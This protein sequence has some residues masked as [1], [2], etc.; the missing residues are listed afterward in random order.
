MSMPIGDYQIVH[1]GTHAFL[2]SQPLGSSGMLLSMVDQNGVEQ[3][4]VMSLHDIYKLDLNADLTVLS[5]CQTALGKD[6]RGEGLVGLTHGFISAGSKSVVASL[7]KVDDRA[8]AYLMAE[9]Y[10]SMLEQ[11]MTPSAALRTA[12]LKMMREKQWNAPYFWAGFVL[13]GEY[14]NRIVMDRNSHSTLVLLVLVPAI[15]I[16]LFKAV[17]NRLKR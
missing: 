9:F 15:S 12:K 16:V 11:N 17:R 4:G 3:D 10:K 1:F 2:N 14:T 13:Q 8:T 7:W 5:A 6:I